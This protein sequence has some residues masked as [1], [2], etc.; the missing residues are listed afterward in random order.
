MIEFPIFKDKNGDLIPVELNQKIPFEVKRVYFLRNLPADAVRGSHA[1]LIEQEVF[2]CIQ[3]SCVAVIDENGKGKKEISLDSP[4]KAIFCDVMCWH[5]FKDF[6][7]D[8]VLFAF[9]S[10]NYLPGEQ[11]YLCDYEEFLKNHGK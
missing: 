6:S 11:N 9:S 7:D 3:G 2:V 4:I 1:H 5:E 8:C 10:T